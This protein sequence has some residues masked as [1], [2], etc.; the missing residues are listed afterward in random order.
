MAV[1]ILLFLTLLYM[2]IGD[3]I[4]YKIGMKIADCLPVYMKNRK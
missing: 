2:I 3:E 4:L 1:P